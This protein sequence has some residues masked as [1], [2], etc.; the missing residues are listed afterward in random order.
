MKLFIILGFWISIKFVVAR[1]QV[2]DLGPIELQKSIM[3]DILKD[4]NQEHVIGFDDDKTGKYDKHIKPP[5]NFEPTSSIEGKSCYNFSF[6]ELV[7]I[8]F[9]NY[10]D[11]TQTRVVCLNIENGYGASLDYYHNGT[12]YEISRVNTPVGACEYDE[13]T[14]Q[15]I[16]VESAPGMRCNQI[17]SMC[18]AKLAKNCGRFYSGAPVTCKALGESTCPTAS[19]CAGEKGSE[20]EDENIVVLD[21]S[22]GQKVSNPS[23]TRASAN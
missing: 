6:K 14:L 9:D 15:V 10:D 11:R 17:Q 4:S 19:E 22:K 2:K 16:K 7:D 3:A 12:K 20:I 23:A 21:Q 13:N 18:I 1:T 5:F 8:G